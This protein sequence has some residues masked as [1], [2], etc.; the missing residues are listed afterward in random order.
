M[1][2]YFWGFFYNLEAR[3]ASYG[4]YLYGRK[5][6]VVCISKIFILLNVG[7]GYGRSAVPGVIVL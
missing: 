6:V 7:N 5:S 3:S 1:T 2:C 4:L